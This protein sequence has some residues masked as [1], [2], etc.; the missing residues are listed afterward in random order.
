MTDAEVARLEHTNQ[1]NEEKVLPVTNEYAAD[2]E[3]DEYITVA[4][5]SRRIHYG[6]QSIYNMISTGIFVEHV[7]YFK[8]TRKKILFCWPAV[9]AW[10]SARAP[11]D[12]PNTPVPQTG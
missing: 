1:E 10:I 2:A 4:Q 12:P 9:K 8:P 7:H 3:S 5:L 6:V 11:E